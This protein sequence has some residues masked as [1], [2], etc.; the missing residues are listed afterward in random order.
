MN[1]EVIRLIEA[2]MATL[3]PIVAEMVRSALNGHDPLDALAK[4]RVATIIPAP[5]LLEL[6]IAAER[7]RRAHGGAP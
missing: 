1:P 2:A 5:L 7:A 3:G 4:E 6:A